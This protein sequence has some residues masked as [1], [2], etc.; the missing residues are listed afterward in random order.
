MKFLKTGFSRVHAAVAAV[1]LTTFLLGGGMALRLIPYRPY[2]LIHGSLGLSIFP[3]WA[4][5]PLLSPKRRNLYR[6]LRAK[7]ILSRAD[8]RHGD[9]LAIA[10]KSVTMLMALTFL[11]QAVTGLMMM[12]GLTYRLFP[13]FGMLSFHTSFPYLLGAL[14]ATHAALMLARRFKKPARK[15]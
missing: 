6:A 11:M 13:N 10:A 1:A 4:L 9:V 12:T 7:A 14:I 2:G 5:L 15:P 3:L 8:F